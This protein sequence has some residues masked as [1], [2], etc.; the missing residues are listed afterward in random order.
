MRTRTPKL[1]YNTFP[2]EL[3][4]VVPNSRLVRT[5]VFV[6]KP[7][8]FLMGDPVL[9]Q[10]Y[11]WVNG[12]LR[13]IRYLDVIDGEYIARPTTTVNNMDITNPTTYYKV[14]KGTDVNVAT[15]MLTLAF[16]N[17]YDLAMLISADSDYIP[18]VE[19]VKR[20]GKNV[21]AVGV[22]GQNL[23]KLKR[24]SDDISILNETFFN[25]CLR[26]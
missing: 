14:E 12:T 13:N 2:V 16:Y 6:P 24:V 17:A 20:L 26:P 1:D 7:D 21:I 5:Y 8:D 3:A 10:Y 9:R 23:T 11:N 25:T 19:Q 22:H 4:S 15:S 18:V